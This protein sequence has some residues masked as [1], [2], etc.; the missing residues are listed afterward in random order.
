MVL[1]FILQGCY[2]G[3]RR[4]CLLF[5]LSLQQTELL[6]RVNLVLTPLQSVLRKLLEMREHLLYL[7]VVWD[8]DL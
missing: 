7:V 3:V 4:I 2:L 5:E 6:N 1:Y 8:L